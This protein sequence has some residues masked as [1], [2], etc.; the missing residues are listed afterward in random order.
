M[1]NSVDEI[2]GAPQEEPEWFMPG[3]KSEAIVR[4][5]TQAVPF[6]NK[7]QA[8]VNSKINGTSYEQ[9]RDSGD[10]ANANALKEH[11]GY[12]LGG[13]LVGGA[14][15]GAG[16][17]GVTGLAALGA[18]QGAGQ[19]ANDNWG[20]VQNAAVGAGVNTLLGAAG[21][22]VNSGAKY[23]GNRY[24]PVLTNKVN[25][26]VAAGEVPGVQRARDLLKDPYTAD[27]MAAMKKYPATPQ[28]QAYLDRLA[29]HGYKDTPTPTIPVR[30]TS[31]DNTY[32]P[33]MV[34][35]A[36][37]QGEGSQVSRMAASDAFSN[38]VKVA[39]SSIAPVVGGAVGGEI[40]YHGAQ[41]LGSN[42]PEEWAA[43]GAGLGGVGGGHFNPAGALAREGASG[44]AD[45]A[46]T[47]ALRYP[48]AIPN[49]TSIMS[50]AMGSPITSTSN[51]SLNAGTPVQRNSVDDIL[52]NSVDNIIPPVDNRSRLQRLADDF[53][54]KHNQPEDFDPLNNMVP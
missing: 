47:Y 29:A 28:Q 34:R 7:I 23:L 2:L 30:N 17:R 33:Q 22:A 11:P 44:L 46:G 1:A 31:P 38:A 52:G 45:V 12:Y 54:V 41:A 6:S 5:F 4:G 21:S 32:N 27:E 9:E 53:Q 43:V 49:A 25:A 18:A 20:V 42:N 40:G 3:S 16:A 36:L 13:Q 35:S 10:A 48:N 37:E 39:K 26:G 8:Y 15:M 14:G 50:G 24:L 51:S 19:T